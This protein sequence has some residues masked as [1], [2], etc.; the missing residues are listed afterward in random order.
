MRMIL[1][2]FFLGMSIF[3]Y[4]QTYK[5]HNP[6]LFNDAISFYK[7]YRKEFYKVGNKYSLDS[8]FIFCI[9]SPEVSNFSIVTNFFELNSLYL[10]Y[11]T[12]GSD[13]GN[14]SVGQF[15]M[16]PFFIEKLEKEILKYPDL[17]SNFKHL[18]FAQENRDS[19]KKRLDRM[20]SISGQMQYLDALLAILQKKNILFPNLEDKLKYYAT[21]YNTGFHKSK[22]QITS[23][24][25]K[26]RFPT[27]S[28][29]KF[30][31]SQ[32]ALEFYRAL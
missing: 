6:S 20:V 28:N 12:G 17:K 7:K 32:I 4:S 29:I 27:F 3:I 19:R 24:F 1:T 8:K 11:L 10:L 22:E 5:D 26:K 23:E 9:V 16:K 30:N 31:Y 14:F 25:S 13:Y 21:A 2:L 18:L 15:Q